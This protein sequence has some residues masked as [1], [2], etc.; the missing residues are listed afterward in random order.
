MTRD[1]AVLRGNT[2]TNR[3]RVMIMA[4][5]FT[6]NIDIGIGTIHRTIT[7]I[8]MRTITAGQAGTMRVMI[9][10]HTGI[11]VEMRQKRI[12]TRSALC[13]AFILEHYY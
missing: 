2:D 11:A 12:T 13:M 5:T 7:D 10:V 4:M 8:A 6:T 9:G 1:W 3:R